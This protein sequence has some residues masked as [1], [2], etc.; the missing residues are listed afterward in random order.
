M[1]ALKQAPIVCRSMSQR[2]C[3]YY[4]ASGYGLSDQT[5]RHVADLIAVSAVQTTAPLKDSLRDR[6]RIWLTLGTSTDLW[7]R[8]CQLLLG[9][10]LTEQTSTP[11]QS[12]HR[13]SLLPRVAQIDHF[14]AGALLG[15]R[16]TAIE[17]LA[18]NGISM[19]TSSPD[20]ASLDN[21]WPRMPFQVRDPSLSR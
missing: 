5:E 1:A 17:N 11:D 15:T 14:L 13:I 9:P 19:P 7:C 20:P 2:E 16:F 6:S 12:G 8:K 21:R 4:F 10:V 18:E 3:P